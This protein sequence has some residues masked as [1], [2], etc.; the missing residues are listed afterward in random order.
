LVPI[1]VDEDYAIIDGHH[2]LRACEELGIKGVPT[3]MRSQL[4]PAEKRDFALALN[5]NRRHLSREQKREVIAAVLRQT[6]REWSNREIARAVGVDHKTVGSVRA[7]L[8]ERGE[9]PH[10]EKLID[11]KGR[12]QPASKA[13]KGTS[14]RRQAS[15]GKSTGAKPGRSRR[16]RA[17]S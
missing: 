16:T 11:S 3:M 2:R 1:I 10:D 7:E 17:Q 14:G 8:V 12:K 15:G 6:T 9:I 13:K 5:L 4:D